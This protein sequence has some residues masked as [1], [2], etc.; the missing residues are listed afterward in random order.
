MIHCKPAINIHASG[1]G[2]YGG[3]HRLDVAAAAWTNLTDVLLG[4]GPGPRNGAGLAAVGSRL[5]VYGGF[6]LNG[7]RAR[8]CV[9]VRARVGAC[10]LEDRW[11]K[12]DFRG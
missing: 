7:A 11:Y 2:L 8:A 12:R 4:D 9:R 3:L 10:V 1:A 5:L 6:G